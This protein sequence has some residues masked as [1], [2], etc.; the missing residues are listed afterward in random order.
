MHRHGTSI[1]PA[2]A[3]ARPV[4]AVRST[5]IA[6]SLLALRDLALEARYFEVLPE[7]HHGTIRSLGVGEWLPIELVAA[8]YAAYDA[9]HLSE[10]QIATIAATSQRRTNG[11]MLRALG[12]IVRQVGGLSASLLVKHIP[13]LWERSFRGGHVLVE[14]LSPK[15]VRLRIS[16]L[17]AIGESPYFRSAITSHYAFG[18][19]LFA[20]S[21]E[22]RVL[23]VVHSDVYAA[24]LIWA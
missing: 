15:D 10:Q 18:L 21:G 6:S 8:H 14:P 23:P 17:R 12:A 2:A 5:L 4:D 16:G 19:G 22:V 1:P 7:S 24:R 3:G 9:M 13:R 20:S 11:A